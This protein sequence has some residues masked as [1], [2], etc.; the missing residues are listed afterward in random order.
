MSQYSIPKSMIIDD[1]INK[2]FHHHDVLIRHMVGMDKL[3]GVIGNVRDETGRSLQLMSESLIISNTAP[4]SRGKVSII[5]QTS[6]TYDITS[7]QIMTVKISIRTNL[8][9]L[10]NRYGG[11]NNAE[12]TCSL[13]ATIM[14][15]IKENNTFYPQLSNFPQAFLG[16]ILLLHQA[17]VPLSVRTNVYAPGY[18]ISKEIDMILGGKD[19]FG[20]HVELALLNQ[21]PV[22]HFTLSGMLLDNQY[23]ED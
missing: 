5:T 19:T 2:L 3:S 10:I 4:K 20:I 13:L 9:Q 8:K 18:S 17:E 12:G 14:K 6:P 11:V 7:D 15:L 23:L 21:P 1:V 16:N 22:A